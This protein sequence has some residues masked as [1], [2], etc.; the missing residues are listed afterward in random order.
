MALKPE[1]IRPEDFGAAGDGK[2]FDT[3]ALQAALD[4]CAELGGG[5]V[6][7][8]GGRTYLSGSLRIGSNTVLH[9]EADA[10]LKAGRNIA[11]YISP[12]TVD[13]DSN[14][15]VG[16]PVTRKPAYVFLY[17]LH[18]KNV[19]ITGQGTIDGNGAAFM[20]RVSPHYVTG[21]FYPRPTLVY[22][23][24]CENLTL[25]GVTLQNA[26]FWTLHPAGCRGV[27]ID[28]IRIQNPLDWA[29][30]DGIDPDHCQNVNIT[31][32]RIECA[33]DCICLKNTAGNSEY[34]HTRGVKISGC[35]LTS[36]SAAVK[37][38]TEGVDDFKDILVEDCVIMRSNRGISIQ[39]RD[40]GSVRGAVFRSLTIETCSFPPDW[41]GS[42]EPIAV[43]A[44]DRD[45]QTRA[46][47]VQ[48]V[49]FAEI[50]CVGEN[51]VLVCGQSGRI[52]G[53]TFDN[54]RVRLKKSRREALGYD[55]RPGCATGD[56]LERP[57]VP[58]LIENSD[59]AINYT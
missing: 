30:S 42:A 49:R 58:W 22:I 10:V 19:A 44:F 7:L 20:R 18:V 56:R 57:R 5:S 9:L 59:V 39:I 13:N 17:G 16:T 36:A 45:E 12:G 43:T 14:R 8:S 31:N 6:L 28:G 52:S 24:D 46:G 41:W 47:T 25:R 51:G 29:N 40:G 1:T 33:D 50:N 55:L 38:G 34:S 23:E 35:T 2:L 26:P 3:A 53:V 48:D 54:V 27:L 15:R 32:C 37:I 4:T 21:D 11:D